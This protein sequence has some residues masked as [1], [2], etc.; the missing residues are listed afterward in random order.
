MST[1]TDLP[2]RIASRIER[3]GSCWIWTGWR[4]PDGYGYAR[5]EGRDQPVHRVVFA[6]AGNAL[7]P[8]HEL[9]HLCL[10]PACC[11]PEHL[12]QVTHA[13]NQRRI[14]L[15]QTSC[16]REGHDWT[17]PRNVRVRPN[18]R[19]WCAECDRVA[20]RARYAKRVAR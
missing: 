12:E 2:D 16:R 11:N 3:A 18:G 6:A 4:N 13:E 1:V 17:D 7:L 9:D 8:G 5:W 14:S 19:R 20:Q 15:R 10:V